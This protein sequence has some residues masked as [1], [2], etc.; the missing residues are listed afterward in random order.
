MSLLIFLLKDVII[1]EENKMDKCSFVYDNNSE[2]QFNILLLNIRR[3]VKIVYET[4]LN[5]SKSQFVN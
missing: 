2:K 3:C 1:I 5:A 4:T